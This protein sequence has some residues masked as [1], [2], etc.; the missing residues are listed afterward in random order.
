[1]QHTAAELERILDETRPR[2]LALE[3]AK[4]EKPLVVEKWSRKEIL[5]HL[6]NSAANNHQRFVR[7]QIESA[8]TLPSYRQPDWVRLQHYQPRRRSELVGLWV[9]YNR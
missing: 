4:I 6:I 7:L 8:L 3:E 1:M 9:P 2:L 5:G